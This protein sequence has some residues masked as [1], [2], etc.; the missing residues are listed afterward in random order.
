MI[1]W[2]NDN[3]ALTWTRGQEYYNPLIS[4]TMEE[5]PHDVMQVG[6]GSS[7]FKMVVTG[8]DVVNA[9]ELICVYWTTLASGGIYWFGIRLLQSPNFLHLGFKPYWQICS[10]NAANANAIPEL[11]NDTWGSTGADLWRTPTADPAITYTFDTATDLVPPKLKIY[12][13]PA[14][15]GEDLALSVTMSDLS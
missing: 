9:G 11:K 2:V 13:E 8:Q 6:S 3:Q 14:A 15:G 7:V 1:T 5:L 12:C 10:G 4:G